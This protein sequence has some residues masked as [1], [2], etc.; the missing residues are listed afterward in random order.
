MK[1]AFTV[2]LAFL[3]VFSLFCGC[4]AY[5][6][7][8][9]ATPDE[10]D[11]ANT[12]TVTAS[13]DEIQTNA[14]AE[15]SSAEKAVKVYMDNMDLWE[16]DAEDNDWYG[17]LFLDLDFDGVLELVSSTNT[18]SGSYSYNKYYRADIENGTVSEIPFPD[19]NEEMQCDFTGTDYP[20]LYK[21]NTTGK[22]KYMTF[23]NLR[24][25]PTSHSVYMGELYLDD[26]GNIAVNELWSFSYK[27]D[28]SN[29]EGYCTY[30]V[31]GDDGTSKSVDYDAYLKTLEQYEAENTNMLLEFKT[32]SGRGTNDAGYTNFADLD[33]DSRYEL[34]LESYKAF[35]YK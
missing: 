15:D 33:Y 12:T 22:L 21:N 25:D 24:E 19:I 10:A 31:P 23:N 28:S 8:D 4:T 34:L 9:T 18:S 26:A 17:Y 30:T 6:N 3:C 13:S 5:N 11:P 14:P 1:K 20:Q 32:V 7:T 29:L 2:I 27:M 35:S 16:A